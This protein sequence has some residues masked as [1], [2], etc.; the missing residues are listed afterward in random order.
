M[1]ALVAYD[2]SK[3]SRR[4][5]LH[6]FLKEYGLNTQ[7]SVFE[8]EVDREGLERIA[9]FARNIIDFETD[10]VRIYLVCSRCMRKVEVIGSGVKL[11]N[12]DYMVL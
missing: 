6:R 5:A 1:I 11:E 2:V 3:N 4:A 9:L 7:K 8:C 10:T 12:L